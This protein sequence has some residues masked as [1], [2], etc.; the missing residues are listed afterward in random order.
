M[1]HRAWRL[2]T[3]QFI[4]V[5]ETALAVAS[6]ATARSPPSSIARRCAAPP[7]PRAVRGREARKVAPCHLAGSG[8]TDPG[9]KM[10]RPRLR[11]R[12]PGRTVVS[13]RTATP[14]ALSTHVAQCHLG[15]SGDTDPGPERGKPRLRRRPSVVSSIALLTV[16][17]GRRHRLPPSTAAAPRATGA[18]SQTA[19][20]HSVTWASSGG[21]ILARKEE[22]PPAAASGGVSM[23]R[24]HLGTS[25][26]ARDSAAQPRCSPIRR[27][28]CRC[29][30][31]PPL[32]SGP[33]LV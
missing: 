25:V 7:P 32:A 13:G 5:P 21:T 15:A 1:A 14:P 12:A 24:P 33:V 28:S 6:S 8:G 20:L 3:V 16:A 2:T 27:R 10:N 22:T 4:F 26:G 29:A 23:R 19:E 18:Q 11:R 9:L 31:A 17:T 30:P